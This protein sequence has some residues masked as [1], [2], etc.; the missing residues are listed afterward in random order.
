MEGAGETSGRDT[1]EAGE[2]DH[3]IL[4][5]DRSNDECSKAASRA[6]HLP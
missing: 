1:A 2:Q 3:L 4:I 6:R 5:G